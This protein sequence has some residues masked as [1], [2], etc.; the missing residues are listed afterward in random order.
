M[1]DKLENLQALIEARARGC[2]PKGAGHV[3]GAGPVG[4]GWI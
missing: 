1:E 4:I 2:T 3:R